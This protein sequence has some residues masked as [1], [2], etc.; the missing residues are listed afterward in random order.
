PSSSATYMT[1]ANPAAFETR[2]VGLTVEVDPV[3]GALGNIIYLGLS[4][5]IT[6]RLEDHYFTVPGREEPAR[7]VE[8]IFM[9]LFYSMRTTTSISSVAGRVNLIGVHTPPHHPQ[10]RILVLI[11]ATVSPS[12]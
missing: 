9:P 6:L 10:E 3:L 11:K 2:N 1:S 8:H 12:H 7:G 4:P 5:E